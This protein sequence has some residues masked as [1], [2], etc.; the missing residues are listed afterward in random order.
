M[1]YTLKNSENQYQKWYKNMQV[2]FSIRLQ[3]GAWLFHTN[4]KP[5]YLQIIEESKKQLF[6]EYFP[7]LNKDFEL[8]LNEFQ[9]SIVKAL[10]D[11]S[12]NSLLDFGLLILTPNASL[13]KI[14]TAFTSWEIFRPLL[15]TINGKARRKDK[16]DF[17]NRVTASVLKKDELLSS[18]PI[19]IGQKDGV[20]ALDKL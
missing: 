16:K 19:T 20:S 7:I 5:D 12:T 8:K 2:K 18:K 10:D 14:R 1:Y 9:R 11:N 17:G 3:K 15:L 6:A 4:D 13:K